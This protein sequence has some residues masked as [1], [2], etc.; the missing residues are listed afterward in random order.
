MKSITNYKDDD[1]KIVFKVQGDADN[2]NFD[3][4]N[5]TLN[6]AAQ[7]D[8]YHDIDNLQLGETLMAP[9]TIWSLVK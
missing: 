6:D 8:N 5:K 7:F 3:D 9:Q 4:E 1:F 2:D